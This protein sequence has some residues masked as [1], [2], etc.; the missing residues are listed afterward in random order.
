MSDAD[1][2]YWVALFY[3]CRSTDCFLFDFDQIRL[4]GQQLERDLHCGQT[5]THP[6]VFN[7]V[8]WELFTESQLSE[9]V[10]DV[11]LCCNEHEQ[12][13]HL[14]TIKNELVFL[15]IHTV[16]ESFNFRLDY[17]CHLGERSELLKGGLAL[18]LY[19]NPLKFFNSHLIRCLS[20]VQSTAH[21]LQRSLVLFVFSFLLFAFPI[22]TVF[23]LRT[24]LLFFLFLNATTDITCGLILMANHFQKYFL[25]IACL[26][27]C[28]VRTYAHIFWFKPLHF[29]F[30][31]EIFKFK[32]E[33]RSPAQRNDQF[34]EFLV[35]KN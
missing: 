6:G 31:F 30:S 33:S 18:A 9:N 13:H 34:T 8:R 32:F 10:I 1:A 11:S 3:P 29:I 2:N 26:V 16:P 15:Y 19:V 28:K 12:H 27:E 22:E 14:I 7:V 20:S 23:K 21:L 24:E 25:E 5:V 17:V 4:I 35:L